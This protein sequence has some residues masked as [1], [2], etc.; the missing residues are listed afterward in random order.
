MALVPIGSRSARQQA[1][2]PRAFG[3]HGVVGIHQLAS[4]ERQAATPNARPEIITHS[5]HVLD[6]VGEYRKPA[7]RHLRPVGPFRSALQ[8]QL[9]ERLLDGD[10]GNA[11]AL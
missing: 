8:W 3:R 2:R 1:S 9:I 11:D 5:F 10:E 6:L 7:C 4:L